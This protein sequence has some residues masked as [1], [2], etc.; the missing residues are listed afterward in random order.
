[1]HFLPNDQVRNRHSLP[2]GKDGNIFFV[3]VFVELDRLDHSVAVPVNLGEPARSAVEAAAAVA[4]AA[5]ANNVARRLLHA[6]PHVA[7]DIDVREVDGSL[8]SILEQSKL[9][10]SA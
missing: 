7:V 9:Q 4:T 1:M 3:Q 10:Y 6:D 8:K 2:S 5:S